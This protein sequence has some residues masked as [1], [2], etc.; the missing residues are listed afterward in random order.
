L[1]K[2]QMNPQ[3]LFERALSVVLA[4][5]LCL[6]SLVPGFA[7]PIVHFSPKNGAFY[8]NTDTGRFWTQDSYEGNGSDPASLHKYTYC[9]GNPVNA[10]D[11]SGHTSFM[12][13]MFVSDISVTS[14]MMLGGLFAG[15]GGYM[16]AL[17][18]QIGSNFN[19]TQ[20]QV[21]SAFNRGF[22][23]GYV[24]GFA[25]MTPAAG[26]AVGVSFGITSVV[27][28]IADAMNSS[29][30]DSYGKWS[31]VLFRASTLGIVSAFA[32][33]GSGTPTYGEMLAADEA[34]MASDFV[35][36][37]HGTTEQM[38]DNL[39]QNGPD[40]NFTAPNDPAPTGGISFEPPGS[41]VSTTAADYA[42]NRAATHPEE[43]GPVVV[44]IM[45]PRWL[46]NLA[47]NYS[48]DGELRFAPGHGLEQLQK[49]WPSVRVK[50]PSKVNAQTPR[51]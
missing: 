27:T 41:R 19:A 20:S 16:S 48:A 33:G 45:I 11:P 29:G 51:H 49:I 23:A 30:D 37:R 44:T 25:G 14:R 17:D 22:A 2:D 39:I 4:S 31:Q 40:A 6:T 46:A 21:N 9:N 3:S 26:L 15:I 47:Y 36:L 34:S 35:V 7:S 18:T 38:A 50:Y 10:Y 12:E 24:F 8:H 1:K 28:G 43:G 13:S 32:F 42:V 5:L